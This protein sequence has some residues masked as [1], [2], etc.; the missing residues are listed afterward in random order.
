V[1]NNSQEAFLL[2][3]TS[4]PL[5]ART[6]SGIE[7]VPSAQ[8]WVFRDGKDRICVDFDRVP[9][10]A[11][12]LIPGLKWTLMWY[13]ANRAPTTVHTS[14]GTFLV[15]VKS[16]VKGR[17]DIMSQIL[18]EDILAF[19]IMSE[20]SEHD[21]AYLRAFLKRWGSLGAPG[22]GKDV[23]V[24]LDQLTL[25][26]HPVGVAVATLDPK[27]GPFTD[28]EFEAIQCALADAYAAGQIDD[29]MFLLSFLFMA[30]GAR[31]A[32]FAAMKLCDLIA[33]KS[34]EE[35]DYIL[36]VPRVKQA[37]QLCRDELKP[38][39]LA[40]QLG[41]ALQRY[42]ET[43]YS[44]FVSRLNDPWQAPLFPQK[45]QIERANAPGF[46]YHP[47]S[48]TISAKVIS[49]FLRLR[50]R[51]E[52]ISDPVPVTPIRFRRTFATRAAEEGL[53]L[54]VIAEM[55]DHANTKHVE[56]YAGLTSR[57]RARLNRAVAMHMAPLAQ[58][59]SG[60][61][62][63]SEADATRPDPSSHIVD[64]RVDQSGV[65]MG[66]CGTDV[67]CG[68]ATPI[69]CYSCNSFEPWLDGPHEAML[70]YLLERRDQLMRTADPRIASVNDR[71]ILGCAQ[72][73]LRCREIKEGSQKNG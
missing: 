59:F 37:D 73:I 1:L 57:I 17:R 61:I 44:Q 65:G 3:R 8:K 29:A 5:S 18:P 12:P 71:S 30:L 70:D 58:A 51:S 21:L 72:V 46:E 15:M 31:P 38:R 68:F 10:L 66:A 69:A 34:T 35:G 22:I 55:M 32:Q 14:F 52:R 41:E 60:R 54:L 26:Q 64:L 28:L 50:V 4:L 45:T 43:V 62:I 42:V 23:V 27:E 40:H 9:A 6:R 47:T 20:R 67:H 56:V 36:M 48:S 39:V 7:Y 25:R 63:R 24:L 33:P 49:G 13:L 19:K 2:S 53:P 11:E 16:L